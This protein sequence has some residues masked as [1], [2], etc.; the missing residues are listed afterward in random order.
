MKTIELVV[1]GFVEGNG[2]HAGRLGAMQCKDSEGN[3]VDVGTGFTDIERDRVWAEREYILGA[4]VEVRVQDSKVSIARHP[5][6][7]RFRTEK[8]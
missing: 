7:V 1:V 4:Q 8:L 5:A 2:K 6:F 3:S